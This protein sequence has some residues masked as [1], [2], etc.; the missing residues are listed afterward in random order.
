MHLRHHEVSGC[1]DVFDQAETILMTRR[2]YSGLPAV[3]RA[4]VRLLR[5]P[6][7]FFLL[8]P[9]LQWWLLYPGH[10]LLRPRQNAAVLLGHALHFALARWALGWSHLAGL[11]CATIIGMTLFHLHHGEQQPAHPPAHAPTHAALE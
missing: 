4:C 1:L 7:V 3:P 2:Q 6:A 9:A 5:D 10:G 8:V 11:Y